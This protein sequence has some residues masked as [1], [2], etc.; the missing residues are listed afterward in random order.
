MKKTTRPEEQISPAHK[1]RANELMCELVRLPTPAELERLNTWL[2]SGVPCGDWEV[3]TALAAYRD[4]GD[5]AHHAG[6]RIED[7]KRS[8]T[9][10][11][12]DLLASVVAARDLAAAG[13]KLITLAKSGRLTI[14]GAGTGGQA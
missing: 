3:I 11:P 5:H 13:E 2:V 1:V 14:L 12:E 9:L 7:G 10:T 4:A 8:L 6:L